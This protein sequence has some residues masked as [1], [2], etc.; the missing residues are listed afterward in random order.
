ML[1]YE[2]RTQ[3][4]SEDRSMGLAIRQ[5][6]TTSTPARSSAD[7]R[8]LRDSSEPQRHR[9]HRGFRSARAPVPEASTVSARPA[10]SLWTLCLCGSKICGNLRNLR[11][12]KTSAD[13]PDK[14]TTDGTDGTDKK[15]TWN[16]S[17]TA[18]R[19]DPYY[20]CNPWFKLIWL[21]WVLRLKKTSAEICAIGG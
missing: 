17:R 7:S 15:D 2:L 9:E 14:S 16:E 6:R 21:R 19:H 20:Q 11:I 12:K 4:V 18:C 5:L 13:V 8:R 10:Q 1:N 3:G